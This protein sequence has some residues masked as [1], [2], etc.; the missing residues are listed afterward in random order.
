M[1]KTLPLITLLH[2]AGRRMMQHGHTGYYCNATSCHH[3]VPSAHV[4]HSHR[5]G[6]QHNCPSPSSP[7]H[8]LLR[9]EC[10]TRVFSIQP[11]P[12]KKSKR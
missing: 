11:R 7:A 3:S 10:H 6:A 5:A 9:T 1:V 12:G 4:P 8:Q 2:M